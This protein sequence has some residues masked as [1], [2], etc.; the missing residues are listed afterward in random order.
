MASSFNT[1]NENILSKYGILESAHNTITL[2]DEYHVSMVSIE[3][4]AKNNNST[5]IKLEKK[6]QNKFC[7]NYKNNET[8][9]TLVIKIEYDM[10]MKLVILDEQFEI[11]NTIIHKK[12]KNIID[13]PYKRY[14]SLNIKLIPYQKDKDVLYKSYPMQF[15][16]DDFYLNNVFFRNTSNMDIYNTYGNFSDSDV[17][18][19]SPYHPMSEYNE[20]FENDYQYN[21][22]EH[23]KISHHIKGVYYKQYER[24][25]ILLFNHN[26]NLKDQ[27]DKENT[28]T[29]SLKKLGSFTCKYCKKNNPNIIFK[30]CNSMYHFDCF[31]NNC[32]FIDKQ[33]EYSGRHCEY[34]SP[35]AFITYGL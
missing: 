14:E 29:E 26:N 2:A 1:F 34:K 27:I 33:H 12:I 31:N 7:I 32:K 15:S 22:D 24:N 5:N 21:I 23:N 25:L 3:I 6:E 10:D 20:E 8:I 18:G 9:F 19:Y 13:I 30:K 17:T 11:F 35:Y 16:R 28:Y 4:L